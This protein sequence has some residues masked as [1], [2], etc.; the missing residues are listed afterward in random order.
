L[1]LCRAMLLK[2]ELE[3]TAGTANT[4]LRAMGAVKVPIPGGGWRFRTPELVTIDDITF[5]LSDRI[6]ADG[7]SVDT[8]SD[9][10]VAI[11][12]TKGT[13]NSVAAAIKM[14]K[15][16]DLDSNIVFVLSDNDEH[17]LVGLRRDSKS[18]AQQLQVWL[19]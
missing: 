4:D 19:R 12:T 5:A 2:H 13:A 8:W 14:L 11:R 3:I 6:A 16:H 7:L 15:D 10:A 17:V 1:D 18:Y 9:R